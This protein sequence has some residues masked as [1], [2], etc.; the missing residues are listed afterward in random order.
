MSAAK[1]LVRVK[2][3]IV[4]KEH[5]TDAEAKVN[6]YLDRASPDAVCAVYWHGYLNFP[7]YRA[8]NE[9][10]VFTKESN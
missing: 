9:K 7:V 6:R 10:S 3:I 8:G 5:W 1:K 4:P 2:R